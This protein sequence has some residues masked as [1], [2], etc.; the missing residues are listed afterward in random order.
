VGS[1]Y[2]GRV[3]D[4]ALDQGLITE[5]EKKDIWCQNVLDWLGVKKEDFG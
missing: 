1:S 5:E 3:L 2:P 4:D